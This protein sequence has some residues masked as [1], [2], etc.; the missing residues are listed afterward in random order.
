MIGSSD[1]N[2]I[3]LLAVPSSSQPNVTAV[4]HDSWA[5]VLENWII[6][7]SN[8]SRTARV[9]KIHDKAVTVS[10]VATPNKREVSETDLFLLGT[11]SKKFL[12]RLT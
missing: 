7:Q 5:E 3:I 11:I 6:L 2:I 9:M 8:N 1:A 4:N 12:N 10:K